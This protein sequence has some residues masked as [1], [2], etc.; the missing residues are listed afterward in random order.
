MS[1]LFRF[2][3]HVVGN[4]SREFGNQIA[5]AIQAEQKQAIKEIYIEERKEY[6][7]QARELFKKLCHQGKIRK[8]QQQV[9]RHLIETLLGSY[10]EEY[11]KKRYDN[12]FHRLYTYLKA[13][14]LDKDDWEQIMVALEQIQ[15]SS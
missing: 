1:K 14:H 15:Y 13:Y 11:K 9:L 7:D 2:A 5:K 10:A 12:E 3:N 8:E 4:Y 6:A